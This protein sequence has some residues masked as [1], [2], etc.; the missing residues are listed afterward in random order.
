M[1]YR[2]K[3]V[4][5]NLG[6]TRKT[7]RMYEQYGLIPQNEAGKY[8]D[9]SEDELDRIWT[10]KVFQGMG[11][12]LNELA[13][14]VSLEEPDFAASLKEKVNELK[15][16]KEEIEKHL[17]YANALLLSGRFPLRPRDPNP[18][19]FQEFHEMALNEWNIDTNPELKELQ[20][21]KELSDT[22]PSEYDKTQIEKTL[23]ICQEV[24]EN[25]EAFM[26]SLVLPKE[27]LKRKDKG[28]ANAEVQLLVKMLYESSVNSSPEREKMTK[29]QFVRI[30]VPYYTWGWVY[31][32]NERE[33][34]KEGC[35]FI[36]N[37]IAVFGGYSC[38]NDIEM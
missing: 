10:I 22:P 13:N 20:E 31:Q 28:V 24:A 37:A 7:L 29:D 25:P 19:K 8:R 36:A 5:D 30:L 11:Y 9:Y 18:I 26:E 2:V 27:I 12:K 32:M 33:Y 14:M 6:I 38:Y 15:K 16:Q 1:G 17:K 35:D 4:E 3:W 23:R 21:L 34:G